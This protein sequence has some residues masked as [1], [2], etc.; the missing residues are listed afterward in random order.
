[1]DGGAYLDDEWA[2]VH[3]LKDFLLNHHVLLLA[4][5]L[6]E[7]LFQNFH[8]ICL[9]RALLLGKVNGRVRSFPKHLDAKTRVD[10]MSV[11]ASWSGPCVTPDLNESN[12]K[13]VVSAPS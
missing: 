4:F 5:L 13:G 6:D 2:K 7:C 8:R 11:D 10:W 1:M 9:P 3:P 12:Q